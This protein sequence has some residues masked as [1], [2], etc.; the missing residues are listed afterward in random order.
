MSTNE[1]LVSLENIILSSQEAYQNIDFEDVRLLIVED[2]RH[3]IGIYDD[4]QLNQIITFFCNDIDEIIKAQKESDIDRV[5]CI[6]R[7]IVERYSFIPETEHSIE[8]SNSASFYK[9]AFKHYRVNTTIV[10]GDSHVNFFRGNEQL[11]FYPIGNDINYCPVINNLPFTI[12]H[13]GPCLA[14]T[15]GKENTTYRFKE[16][17]EFLRNTFIRPGSQIILVL[18][19][20]DIRAHVFKQTTLQDKSYKEIV[21]NILYH[22]EELISELNHEGYKVFVYG[23]IATQPDYCEID[24]KFPRIGSEIDRNKATLYFNESIRQYCQNN[25]ISFF[26]LFDD[27]VNDDLYTLQDFLSP[28]NCHLGQF[29]SA[30]LVD[31]LKNVGILKENFIY[32]TFEKRLNTQENCVDEVSKKNT[33]PYE[34][35]AL[36]MAVPKDYLRLE[37]LYG[38]LIDTMPVRKICFVGNDEVGRLVKESKYSDKLSFVNENDILRFDDVHS[39]MSKALKDRLNGQELPRGI[40]GWYYQ[41]FLKMKY[42]YICK[43]KYYLVWDGDTVPCAS[44]SMFSKENSIPYFDLKTEYH[45]EYFITLS[46]LL[47]GMGKVIKKSFISEH[48]LIDCDIMK[49]LVQTIE[50]NNELNGKAFFEKIIFSIPPEKLT[51]NSFSEFETYGT[52]TALKHMNSY[53]LRDWHSFR[54]G[55]D[56][57]DSKKI[58]D[59]DFEWLSHDFDAISFEKGHEV[60]DDHKNLFDNKEYQSKLSARKML[61]I[62]Q[63]EFSDDSFKESWD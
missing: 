28:D 15:C 43:D 1:I 50:H 54:Y 14:Y 56:F 47:P 18:G 39:A 40:T 41:Q 29:G 36:I 60:R 63:E 37:H 24:E 2:L 6:L 48:M 11:R 30:L 4:N 5:A 27:M 53:R 25:G 52:Y 46:K 51:S 16:K 38:R 10:L 23:P 26:T 32:E 58:D 57:F 34:Y 62:A 33:E 45:E 22:Y 7:Q 35:D 44:F 9:E 17:L 55:G 20:I 12:L 49:E 21:D 19:E 61:E 42:A 59:V 13:L 31:K 8:Y 3:R